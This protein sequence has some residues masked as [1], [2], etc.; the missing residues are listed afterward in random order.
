[1]AIDLNVENPFCNPVL[2]TRPDRH[3]NETFKGVG[4]ALSA[5][6]SVET[7]IALLYAD[8]VAPTGTNGIILYSFSAINTAN[9]RRNLTE[10]AAN[11]YFSAVVSE[12]LHNK[13]T[14]ALTLYKNASERRNEVAHGAVVGHPEKPFNPDSSQDFIQISNENPAY[15]YLVLPMFSSRKREA[16]FAAEKYRYAKVDLRELAHNF[17]MLYH[18][19]G[20]LTAEIETHFQSLPETVRHI[21]D[22]QQ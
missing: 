3:Q 12:A 16:F 8:F 5:F 21:F 18:F 17:T 4:Q 2:S 15:Y 6:E 10:L 14:R 22:A 9:Q 19:V 7:A 13:T 20:R 1:M 11:A